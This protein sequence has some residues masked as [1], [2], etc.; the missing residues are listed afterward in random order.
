MEN[1]RNFTT[2]EILGIAIKS[3]ID[4]VKLY[5]KMRNMVKSEDLKDK[6]VFL[7][8]QEQKHERLLKEAYAK[9]FPEIEL[10]LPPKAIV[11]RIDEVLSRDASLKELFDV[12]L[13]AERMAEEFYSELAE[14]TGEISAKTMLIYMANM[15]KSHFAILEA[16]MH[17]IEMLETED[18]RKFLDSDGLQ[19]LGP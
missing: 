7:I 19:F 10:A 16:E 2:L 18:T 8:S 4:A 3:E 1:N 17:N 15:E 14:K 5:T 12:A 11:P 13:E 6:M 9:Q